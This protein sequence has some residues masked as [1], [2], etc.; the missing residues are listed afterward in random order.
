MIDCKD[1][2]SLG[3]DIDMSFAR[4]WGACD[5]K[6]LLLADPFDQG[7]RYGLV[8]SAHNGDFVC[9]WYK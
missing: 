6:K 2:P 7:F 9:V 1:A 8:V 5:V 3:R 4:Q